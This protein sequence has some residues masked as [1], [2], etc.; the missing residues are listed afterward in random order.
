MSE[1]K[2]AWM[3]LFVGI[4]SGV[5]LCIWR[6]L[7]IALMIINWV[8]VIFTGKRLREIAEFSEIWNTQWYI[9]Q[10]YM[11]FMTNRRPFPFA[12]LE[13]SMSKYEHHHK[14]K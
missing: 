2:E 9:F 6:W 5:I 10:R 3:R 14:K 11:I 13:K 7:I 12:N 1:R 8:Y 4:I